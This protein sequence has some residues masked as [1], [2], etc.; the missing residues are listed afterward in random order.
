MRSLCIG[1][2]RVV[3]MVLLSGK[4]LNKERNSGKNSPDGVLCLAIYLL[5]LT[6][7][8]GWQLGGILLERQ[9]KRSSF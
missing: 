7:E 6:N 3:Q 5:H 8:A 9:F 2:G 1:T 4:A